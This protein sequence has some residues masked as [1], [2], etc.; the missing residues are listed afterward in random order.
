MSSSPKVASSVPSPDQHA[1]GLTEIKL[2]PLR[3]DGERPLDPDE[4]PGIVAR[5]IPRGSRVLDVGCGTGLL[6]KNL[7]DACGAEFIGIEPDPIRASRA[8]QRGLQIHSG[9]L[10]HE[11]VAEIGPVD[12][13][14]FADVLEHLPS[15]QEPLLISLAAL[16]PGGSVI[17]SVPNVVHWSVRMDILRGR[18]RYADCGIMDATHLRWFTLPSIS[19]LLESAGLRVIEYHGAPAVGTRDT[20]HRRPLNVLSKNQRAWLLRRGCRRWPTLF[21]VQYVLRAEAP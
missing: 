19:G 20:E 8:A 12:I 5:M 10:S 9:V 13:V 17:V 2:D 14:L 15:P 1:A 7:S 16:K 4:V 21:A 6:A 11:L 18:F 3:Y